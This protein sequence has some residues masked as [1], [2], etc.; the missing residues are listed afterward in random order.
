MRVSAKGAETDAIVLKRRGGKMIR[1]VSIWCLWLHALIILFTTAPSIAAE[2]LKL[3]VGGDHQNPPFEFLENGA[4]TGF[5]VDVM[6]AAAQVLGA[7]VEFRLR[8]WAE[9]RSALERGTIDALAGM[10]YSPERSR[11]VDFSLPHTM[12]TMG[13][14]VRADSTIQSIED[15]RGKEVIVQRGDIV[16]DYLREN[17]ITPHI[18][19]VTDP[20]DELRLLAS[21]RHDCALM[22]SSLQ[23]EYLMR[24]L[25]LSNIKAV[26]TNLP[27]LRYCFAVTNGNSALRY[28]IDEALNILK[29]NGEYKKIY[30]N[31]F[32]VYEKRDLWQTVRYFVWIMVLVVA[33]LGASF[34]WSWSLRR[35]VRI[36]TAE[37][38][39]REKRLR[40][41]QYAIDKTIVQAFW[42]TEDGRIFYVNDAACDAL[43]YSFD[44]LTAMSISDIDPSFPTDRLLAH[45][46]KLPE[47]GSFTMESL[48]RTKDGRAY[49]VDIRV[50]H[51]VF[52]GKEYKCAFVTDITESK[53]MQEA[54][55]QSH[56]ELE[57][58]VENRTAALAETVDA[59][60]K[61]IVE[62]E[63]AEK[64]IQDLN[65]TLEERIRQEVAKNREKDIMLI[66]QNRQAALGEILDHIAHQWKHPLSTISLIAYL[67]KTD[68]PL[69]KA[70]VGEA[71]DSIIAQVKDLT[72]MLNDYRDFYRPDKEK[73]VFRIKK[74]IEKALSCIR[75]VLSIESIALEVNA[76]P[77]LRALG[78]PKE[79]AQVILNLV[80]N[81]RDAFK[82]RKVKLPRIVVNGTPDHN[83]AVVTVT[84]NAGGINEADMDSIFKMNFTTKERIGGTGIGLYMSRN[85]IEKEMGGD[86]AAANVADGAQFCIRLPIAESAGRPAA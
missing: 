58:R 11:R 19:Q 83:M 49:P 22:P 42:T 54:L 72:Q 32:G 24:T 66:Q 84:D 46:R 60:Q 37:L 64:A 36:R 30:D 75:P 13:L 2:K 55:Q 85:I 18:V 7:E 23:S 1:S 10:Y 29:V 59:L 81:A 74:G 6:R 38:W 50:N 14:Y 5:N 76:D 33:L 28:R 48:H 79:F 45:K 69:N 82:E 53:K 47:S 16:D 67:L 34:I 52:D 61:E 73:S 40:F 78:Y 4:P 71:T 17:K 63:K 57:K 65:R 12:V 26:G 77:D 8:P 27:Q 56:D 25:G 9:V 35:Q 80:G 51:V 3:V 39:E 43:G 15:I 70:S 62:R 21:G 31:W 20:A 86:L 44:E 68:N 41:T